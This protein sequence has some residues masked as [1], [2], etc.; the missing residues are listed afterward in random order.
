[1][2]K[3]EPPP[4]VLVYDTREQ[5]PFAL[6]GFAAMKETLDAGDYSI[7]GYEDRVA[8]ERKSYLDAWGSMSTGRARFERCVKR[9]AA[10][11]RAA[12]VIECSLTQL[13]TQ[14]G[15][16]ERTT[17]ASVVGGLISWSA[18]YALPVFFCD[19]REQAERVTIRFLAS[20]FKHRSGLF[21]K[22]GDDGQV[23]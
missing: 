16:I 20:W 17:P 2:A 4:F 6:T 7:L 18:Q 14:P 3:F 8:V 23:E 1:M 13:A 21:V 15:R 11:D 5:L 22:G 12:I 19:T 10:L 9:L